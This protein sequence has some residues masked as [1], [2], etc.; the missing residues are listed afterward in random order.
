MKL[1]INNNDLSSLRHKNCDDCYFHHNIQFCI[2]INCMN[3]YKI[4]IKT[5][6]NSTI[7]QL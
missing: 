5:T 6:N 2:Y 1:N 4:Y 3:D 7:F